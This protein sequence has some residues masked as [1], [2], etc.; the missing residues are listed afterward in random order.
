MKLNHAIPVELDLNVHWA[1][2]MDWCCATFGGKDYYNE[3]WTVRSI[4]NG[5]IFYFI[6]EE[7]AM[8]FTLKWL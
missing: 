4:P 7:D 3:R 2:A 1:T 8:L 6:N 5:A